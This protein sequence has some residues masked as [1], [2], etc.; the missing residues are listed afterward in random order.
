MFESG[1]R[2]H[3]WAH[4]H[5]YLHSSSCQEPVH[6][7][8]HMH[9]WSFL[10]CSHISVHS[11]HYL[12]SDTRLPLF[13]WH[14]H[15]VTDEWMR[16]N[17]SSQCVSRCT[18][19]EVCSKACFINSPIRDKFHPEVVGG[20]PDIFRFIIATESTNQRAV[21]WQPISNLQIVICTAVMPLDLH[22]Q[23]H[24]TLRVNGISMSMAP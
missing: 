22:E 4:T 19:E 24:N 23:R 9:I 21:L 12:A 17:T 13:Y 14:R 11:P 1:S 2:M 5:S 6:I 10:M 20:G 15:R 18:F 16:A 3:L 8:D 7:Q